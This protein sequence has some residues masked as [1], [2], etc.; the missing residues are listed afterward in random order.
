MLIANAIISRRT[1]ITCYTIQ[2]LLLSRI[3]DITCYAWYCRY[4]LELLTVLGRLV[5]LGVTTDI[6]GSGQALRVLRVMRVFRT[7][8]CMCNILYVLCDALRTLGVCVI[9]CMCGLSQAVCMCDP[10]VYV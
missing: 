5:L 4:Y 9:C 6:T 7:L 2:V 3:T 1:D 10:G 8:V